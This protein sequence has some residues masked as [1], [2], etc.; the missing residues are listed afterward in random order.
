MNWVYLVARF[1]RFLGAQ[2][3]GGEA[4]TIQKELPGQQC[5][6]LDGAQKACRLTDMR[7]VGC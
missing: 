1:D 5:S 6:W 2:H 3:S 7:K 4:M